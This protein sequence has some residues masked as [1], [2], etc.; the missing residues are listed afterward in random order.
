M[1]HLLLSG[2]MPLQRPQLGV[3]M[4]QSDPPV[5]LSAPLCPLCVW[6]GPLWGPGQPLVQLLS[7]RELVRVHRSRQR[8]CGDRCRPWAG[9]HRG[10]PGAVRGLPH[11]LHA[12]GVASAPTG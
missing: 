6:P 2:V 3:L 12:P 4:G 5:G 1:S 10:R 9:R 8:G 7:A 11:G